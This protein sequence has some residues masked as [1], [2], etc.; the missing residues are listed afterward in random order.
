MLKE[1]FGTPYTFLQ[2]IICSHIE[3]AVLN[4]SVEVFGSS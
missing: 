1:P 4:S 3:N 2:I